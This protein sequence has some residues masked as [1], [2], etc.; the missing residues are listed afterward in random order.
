L[1][2]SGQIFSDH[3]VKCLPVRLWALLCYF[4]CYCCR[5]L[6]VVNGILHWMVLALSTL[7]MCITL[8]IVVVWQLWLHHNHKMSI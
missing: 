2:F 8:V 7:Q 6:A 5:N 4:R 3:P 1:L